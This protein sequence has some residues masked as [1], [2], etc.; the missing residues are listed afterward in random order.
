M[1]RSMGVVVAVA[2]LLALTA[3]AAFAG[4]S[5]SNVQTPFYFTANGYTSETALSNGTLAGGK[6]IVVNPL[7]QAALNITANVVGLSPDTTY[8]FWIRGLAAFSYSGPVIY[9]YSGNDYSKMAY[10]TTDAYGDGSVHLT[11]TADLMTNGSGKLQFA[12]N[13]TDAG[14][15]ASF[16]G[17]TIIAT[18]YDAQPLI[19]VQTYFGS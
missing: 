2:A 17:N 16:I 13:T 7:G 5:V 8:A 18:A 15:T 1:R 3:P 11:L 19:T 9:H 10:F 14:L 6:V 12:V 4:K